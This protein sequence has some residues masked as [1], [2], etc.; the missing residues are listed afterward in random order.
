MGCLLKKRIDIWIIIEMTL[1]LKM[2]VL[3]TTGIIHI[4]PL[5]CK[6]LSELIYE[7]TN[8]RISITTL[9]RVYGFAVTECNIS[10]YTMDAL[11]EFSR[12]GL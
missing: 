7:K 4:E 3:K 8:K 6:I 1:E 9:K 5:H 2:E 11:R 12:P 10:R